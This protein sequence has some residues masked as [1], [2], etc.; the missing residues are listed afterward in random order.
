MYFADHTKPETGNP[1]KRDPHHDRH[2]FRAYRAIL[3]VL[4]RGA[5]FEALAARAAQ[6]R[7][8]LNDAQ[9]D[10]RAHGP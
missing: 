2:P 3:Y 4:H 6:R 5:D 9:I 8:Y 10:T 1:G 7:R